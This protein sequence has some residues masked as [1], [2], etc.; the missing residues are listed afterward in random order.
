MQKL[1]VTFGLAALLVGIGCSAPASKPAMPKKPAVAPKVQPKPKVKTGRDASSNSITSKQGA[2]TP[3]N[4]LT[5]LF[6][7]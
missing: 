4:L 1:A 6:G 3:G 7:N 2:T 5:G